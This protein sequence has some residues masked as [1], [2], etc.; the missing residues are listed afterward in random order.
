MPTRDEDWQPSRR[1]PPRWRPHP[2]SPTQKIKKRH[3]PVAADL[4]TADVTPAQ[5]VQRPPIA[6]SLQPLTVEETRAREQAV[7][8]LT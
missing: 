3:K 2:T 8:L 1:R 4:T 6:K 7:C 5:S